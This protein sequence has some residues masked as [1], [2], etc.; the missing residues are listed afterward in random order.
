MAVLRPRCKNYHRLH[1]SLQ[2]PL[3]VDEF[4]LPRYWPTIYLDFLTTGFSSGTLA[5]KATSIDIFYRYVE[6]TTG[7]GIN[8]DVA[9]VDG[10]L[11]E[12]RNLL[13]GF[14]TFLSNQTA[15]DGMDRTRNWKEAN[16]FLEVTI[17][18]VAHLISTDLASMQSELQT[19]KYMMDSLNPPKARKTRPIRALKSF[20]VSELLEIFTPNSGSNPFRTKGIQVRNFVVFYLLLSLGLRKSELLSLTLNDIRYDICPKKAELVYW[21]NVSGNDFEEIDSRSDVP[22]LKNAASDRQLPLSTEAQQVL[23]SYID[24]VRG[25]APHPY[26]FNSQK[27]RPLS[28]QAVDDLF[29]VA[30]ERLTESAKK[31][32]NS[33]GLK[34][35]KPHSLRHTAVVYRLSKLRDLGYD[36][37]LAFQK[38][39]RYFGWSPNSKMP[40]YY[41]EAYYEAKFH[42]VW[43]DDLDK[44]LSTLRHILR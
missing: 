35:V 2:K 24:N 30:S 19:L 14:L 27:E 12:I 7:A 39:R 28:K 44:T 6:R 41:G 11:D 5:R 17:T 42:E 38:L 32:I 21:I 4:G 13:T 33:Q 9:I 16:R 25:P 31:L 26:I 8:L 43:D 22:G 3:V 20:V 29:S 18:H 34:Q 23:Q 15:I 40:V 1:S 36:Q 37:D 10:N